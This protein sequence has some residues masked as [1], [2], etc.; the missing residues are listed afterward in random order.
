MSTIKISQMTTAA[1]INPGAVVPIVQ[2]G[3]NF[4]VD[5]SLLSGAGATGPQGVS[6]AQG[7]QGVSGTQGLRGFQG[8]QGFQGYKGATGFQG[9]S[10]A[11]GFQGVAGTGG[12]GA[13]GATGPQGP[14]GTQ[15]FQGAAGGGATGAT[16]A[17]GYS[18]TQGFQGAAGG[19]ATGATGVSGTAGFQGYT[20]ATG[21]VSGTT[22]G[23]LTASSSM[24]LDF[25]T[26]GGTWQDIEVT[27]SL[28]GTTFSYN[29]K[30]A[31]QTIKLRVRNN[32]SSGWTPNWNTGAQYAAGGNS[33]VPA[34]SVG[35][36]TVNCWGTGAAGTNIEV[37][38]VHVW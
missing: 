34:T 28:L 27:G 5:A 12:F 38:P 1:S 20:G 15:G 37:S 6:G 23:S 13:T 24:T 14:S 21:S 25:S 16:G 30:T 29:N 18:G 4:K 32:G 33:T 17:Q 26:Q 7:F 22:V 10:G 8:Y 9:P 11:Q 36:Y 19:G 3:A 2:G 35:Y 31:G